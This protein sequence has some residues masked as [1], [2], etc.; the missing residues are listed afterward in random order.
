MYILDTQIISYA[1]KGAYDGKVEQQFI[2]SI[3]AKEFLLVQNSGPTKASYYLPLRWGLTQPGIPLAKHK[4][5]KRST[6]QIVLDFAQDYPSIIEYG[7]FAISE[8]INL[9]AKPVIKAAIDHIDREQR[10]LIL[11]RFDFLMS[12]QVKSLPLNKNIIELGLN[13]FSEFIS[14]YSSKENYRNTVNDIL[15][16][17]TAINSSSTLITRDSLLNRFAAEYY[18]VTVKE[19][20][21]IFLIDFGKERQ[22]ERH[23]SHESKGYINNGWKVHARNFQGAWQKTNL[24]IKNS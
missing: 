4:Y 14:R 15:I 20:S 8:I 16:L 17:A 12:Q 9:R 13:L 6:D 5:S 23:T 19:G 1:F 18:G 10:K 3:T 2:S 21:D 24:R 22:P 7:N 11:D